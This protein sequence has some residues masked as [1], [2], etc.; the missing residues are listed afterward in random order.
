M[1]PSASRF[2]YTSCLVHYFVKNFEAPPEFVAA[3][4]LE[5]EVSPEH[6]SLQAEVA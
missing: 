1:S 3:L 2:R 4:A 5:N 6:H